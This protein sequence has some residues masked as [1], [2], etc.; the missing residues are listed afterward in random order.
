ME[1]ADDLNERRRVEPPTKRPSQCAAGAK[2][3]YQAQIFTRVRAVQQSTAAGTPGPQGSLQGVRPLGTSQAE[4]ESSTGKGKKETHTLDR[5]AKHI[6]HPRH[7][8]NQKKNLKKAHAI[9]ITLQTK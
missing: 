6:I 7:G 4:N 1:L 8:R 3:R 9:I 2:G 5:V